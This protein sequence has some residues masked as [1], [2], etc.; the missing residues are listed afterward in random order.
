MKESPLY[1]MSILLLLIVAVQ[2]A[3]HKCPTD[4]K[5]CVLSL[6]TTWVNVAAGGSDGMLK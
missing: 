3:S 1:D 2:P 6:G 4:I 5:E